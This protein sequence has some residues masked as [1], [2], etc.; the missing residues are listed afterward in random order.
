MILKSTNGI[1]CEARKLKTD[2]HRTA[3]LTQFPREPFNIGQIP[4]K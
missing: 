1:P 4:K 2:G 3:I